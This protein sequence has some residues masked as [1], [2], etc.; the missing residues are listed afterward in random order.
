MSTSESNQARQS[1]RREIRE[2]TEE[3]PADETASDTTETVVA[4]ATGVPHVASVTRHRALIRYP[5]QGPPVIQRVLTTVV[6]QRG[7]SEASVDPPPTY[8]ALPR[9]LREK[10]PTDAAS[11][12]DPLAGGGADA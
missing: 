12:S 1:L 3:A 11:G 4:A 8:E 5:P 7:D 2:S 6:S 9:D 10:L